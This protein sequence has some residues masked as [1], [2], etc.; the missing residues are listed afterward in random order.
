M[1]SLVDHSGFMEKEGQR[2]SSEH[3]KTGTAPPRCPDWREAREAQ[4]TP[5]TPWGGG[6]DTPPATLVCNRGVRQVHVQ[7]TEVWIQM[8][9]GLDPEETE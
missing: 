9:Q 8:R 2:D 7:G 3:P 1:V 6:L 4:E 5:R